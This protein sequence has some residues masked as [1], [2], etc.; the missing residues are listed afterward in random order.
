MTRTQT[1]LAALAAAFI[2]SAAAA[3]NAAPAVPWHGHDIG[4][5]RAAEA[6]KPVLINFTADWCRYCR[7][8]KAETYADPAVAA[9]MAEHFVPVLVDTD[10][11]K[12]LQA[13]Y[14]ARSL[15]TIWFLTSE[16]ERITR[17]PGF[18]PAPMFLSILEY[19]ATESY[20][21][22]DFEAFRKQRD[23]G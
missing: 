1:I 22:M 2:A 10:R 6:G 18:V 11:Q 7:K 9:Y 19:I 5:E 12:K 14:G 23:Q 13:R 15:P 8:M 20:L 3:E 16:G 4:L 21:T 17:L